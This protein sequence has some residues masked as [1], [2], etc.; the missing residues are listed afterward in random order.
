MPLTDTAVKNAKAQ[1]K[2]VKLFDSEGLF[3]LVAPNGGKWWRL[4]YRF[5]KKEKL[6]SLGVYPEISLKEARRRR[7]E[8]RTLVRGGLNAGQ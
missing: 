7:D 4:K 1:D 6:L 8:A 5:Q 2:K 3:L